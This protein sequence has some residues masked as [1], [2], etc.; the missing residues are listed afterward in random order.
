MGHDHNLQLLGLARKAGLLAIGGDAVSA[1]A[2]AEK[3]ILVIS[4][5]D[6]SPGALRRAG[7]ITET[8]RAIN[9]IV[10]YTKFELGSI[11]GRGSPGTIAV[12]D[13]GLAAGFMK[14]LA[15]MDPERYEEAAKQLAGKVGILT[16]KDKPTATK[17]RTAQ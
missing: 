14:G 16:K 7:Y 1:A 6:A 10:P 2:R 17:R 9:V 15:G 3:A 13:A 11:T 4:A 8:S 12:L 5:S